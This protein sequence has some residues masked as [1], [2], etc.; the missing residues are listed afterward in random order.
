MLVLGRRIDERICIGD[1]IE[2]IVVDILK[3]GG[4]RTV[5][6]GITAPKDIPV[7]RKE[8]QEAIDREKKK[9]LSGSACIS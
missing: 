6:L 9:N 4:K 5:R 2:I 1:D 7:H 8:I 3:M